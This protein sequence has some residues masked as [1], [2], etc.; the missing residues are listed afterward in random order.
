MHPVANGSGCSASE[1]GNNL[2]RALRPE[3]A[4]RLQ[5]HLQAWRGGIGTVLY[6]PGDVVRV[7]YF[8]CGPTLVSYRV[9]LA[10]GRGVETALIGRE[11]AVGGIVSQG[12]LPAYA[13][14]VVQSPGPFLQLESA[15]LEEL[16]LQS[17]SLRH[18]FARYAD[19]LIAQV[20]QSTACN[21][22]HTIEQRT[23]R[24]LLA[25][26]DRT[27]DADLPLTQEQLAGML[28][29]GRSYVSRIIQSLKADGVLETRR[30]GLRVRSLGA[31]AAL[32][33]DCNEA[34]RHHFEDVL[35]GVYPA[36]EEN[37]EPAV[38]GGARARTG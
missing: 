3:D 24:W 7:V 20:F 14:A 18:L 37:A 11:G 6:E 19:C 34:V 29:I 4:E 27:G 23:A 21:A 15:K 25:A 13:R 26:I 22:V 28:G 10:D 1:A 8:P 31:L 36:E 12:R 38:A 33:C 35:A 16:K 5:P 17:V 9:M 2:L 30:G 32:G